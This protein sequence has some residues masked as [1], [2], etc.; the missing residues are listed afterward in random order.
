MTT[1]TRSATQSSEPLDLRTLIETIPAM[2][3]CALPDGS[4][5][6]ANRSW[7]E[8]TGRT[9]QQLRGSGWQA[10]IHP[11]DVRA[12]VDEWNATLATGKPFATEVRLQRGDG[13]YHWF[14]IRKALA[15]SPNPGSDSSLRTLI[16]CEDINDRKQAEAKLRQSETQL[17]AFFENS[18]NM[19]F[20]KDR[21][22]RYL[23][24]NREFKRARRIIA[25]HIEGKTDD[26]LFPV[27][28]VTAIQANDRQVLETGVPMVFEEV[29][30]WEDGQHTRIVQKFPLF[31][32]E[33]EIYGIGGIATDITERKREESARRY[34]EERHRLVVET[35]N[36]AVVSMDDGGVI[37]FANPATMRIFGHDPTELM[38]KP[39]TVLMPEFMRKLHE[40]GFRR[41]LATGQQH[42][43]WQGTELT[44]LRKNGEEFPVEVSF[45]E[46]TRDGHKVFTGFIRDISE[47]KQ[48]EDRLRRAQAEL[49]RINRVSTMGELTASLAHEIKQPIGAAVTN[50][51]ACV[52]LLE[53]DQP[54][55][56]EAREAALEAAKD[57]TRAADIIDRV[58]SLYQ[59]GSSQLE[60]VD[61]NQV[62]R[63]MA[64]MLRNEA[65]RHRVTVHTDLVEGLPEVMAD[66]VQL[67]QA[68]MN[69]MLNGVEAMRD[70][71]GE[72]G[73]NSQLAEDGQL[74]ISVIDTGVGL[75]TEDED[76][77]KIF[78]A[79]FTT[80]SQGTGLGLAITRSIIESHGGR[81]WATSNAGR[82]AT[83]Q[84]TLPGR[85]ALAA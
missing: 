6:F 71:G 31:D 1:E 22:G 42:M 66:R 3:L 53:R 67:Q 52:R 65:D 46:L 19:I 60:S 26:E 39:L 54:D 8:Y 9:L 44:A 81:V 28:Q 83:F 76:I 10:P 34:T 4:V 72:L 74:L 7:Q 12:F 57:A 85:V 59:K 5:E 51:E 15:I 16:A 63:E 25:E 20:M 14:L 75:P 77:D 21:Q 23:Y 78:D 61:V 35:A 55:L 64:V 27:E 68:L 32:A 17:Q 11:D 37:M 24:A 73:I 40:A 47:R 56:P 58:R 62:I 38:G 18:P 30:V 33:G 45:G 69:L 43:N 50:A 82:G 84:F 49:A 41:Y 36:D 13:Q 2:V 80:K 79:F 29:T 70:T 48:A